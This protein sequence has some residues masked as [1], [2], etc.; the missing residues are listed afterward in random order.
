[1]ARKLS[2]FENIFL[3][4][5]LKE[6]K[7]QKIQEEE[8]ISY[9]TF[10]SN[11]FIK[12]YVDEY[13]DENEQVDVVN[14]E[15][16]VESETS[17]N[18]NSLITLEKNYDDSLYEEDDDDN[19]D[20]IGNTKVFMRSLNFK[21]NINF[22]ETEEDLDVTDDEYGDFEDIDLDTSYDF[23]SSLVEDINEEETEAFDSLIEAKLDKILN[24]EE[25]ATEE[26]M[27][28][29]ES[30]QLDLGLQ[31]ELEGGII[32]FDLD[33]QL[34]ITDLE[35]ATTT[36]ENELYDDV[37]QEDEGNHFGFDDDYEENSTFEPTEEASETNF[38]VLGSPT[39]VDSDEFSEKE[40]ENDDEI[41]IPLL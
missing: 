41:N 4:K 30:P 24:S 27:A 37:A 5:E 6:K 23:D 13:V 34:D 31:H 28:D 25:L 11:Q 16:D 19:I 14:E 21:S 40:K 35:G 3:N 22:D 10:T 18:V 2:F 29:K 15:V 33:D 9:Q 1:M 38:P 26:L 32:H 12:D 17:E 20:D 8:A 39:S 36:F 7:L